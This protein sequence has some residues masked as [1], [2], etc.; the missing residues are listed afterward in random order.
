MNLTTDFTDNTDGKAILFIREI[1]EIRGQISLVA[2][3]RA[4]FLCRE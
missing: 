3:G 2:V 1:R 4:E